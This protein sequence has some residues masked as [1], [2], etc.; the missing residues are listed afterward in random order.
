MFPPLPETQAPCPLTSPLVSRRAQ[1]AGSLC[2]GPSGPEN[3]GPCSGTEAP[4][5][6]KNREMPEQ[7]Y[8]NRG[9]FKTFPVNKL[10]LYTHAHSPN[11]MQHGCAIHKIITE[12]SYT[13]IRNMHLKLHGEGLLQP[14]S[15]AGCE[16]SLQ[17]NISGRNV[18]SFQNVGQ[19]PNSS[20]ES[21]RRPL[22]RLR[23]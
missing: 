1:D 3:L 22:G 19:G 9:V 21:R 6:L 13:Q 4:S 15:G 16:T 18:K 5:V 7:G 12:V 23:L 8:K 11:I 2:Q 14:I 20:L 17:G 10:T